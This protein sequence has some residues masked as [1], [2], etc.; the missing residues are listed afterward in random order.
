MRAGI[1]IIMAGFQASDVAIGNLS[2]ILTSREEERP[3]G[4]DGRCDSTQGVRA[5]SL[6]CDILHLM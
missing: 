4:P 1:S 5:P 6:H 3:V 2:L